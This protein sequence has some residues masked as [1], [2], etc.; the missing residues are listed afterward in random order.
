MAWPQSDFWLVVD[1]E[2]TCCDQKSIP[3]AEMET[4]EI[5]IVCVESTTFN[6]I[7]HFQAF[8]KPIRHPQLTDFCQQLTTISQAQVDAA[9]LYPEVF[10][11]V[12]SWC[13]P[14]PNAVFAAWG[15]FDAKQLA[16]DSAFHQLPALFPLP[17]V[18]IKTLFAEAYGL[19]RGVGLQTALSMVQQPF[20][21]QAHRAHPDALNT[22][23]L[24]PGIYR[25]MHP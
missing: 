3:A 18:N 1:L 22:A 2:A 8:I 9:A 17:Q 14:Y 4:I 21:G 10:Q 15:D 24:L 5:G 20:E 25:A 11:K 19:K 6:A 7:D 23:K 13:Q 16:R 12:Q